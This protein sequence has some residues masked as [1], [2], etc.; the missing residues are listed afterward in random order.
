MKKPRS[1]QTA[2]P[3]AEAASDEEAL[4]ALRRELATHLPSA[5]REALAAYRRFSEGPAPANAK[6]FTAYQHACRAALAHVQVLVNLAAMATEA[7]IDQALGDD[8]E[9][10]TLIEAART[11]LGD[12]DGDDL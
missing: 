9:L 1:P 6:A 10:Q 11:A 4:A 12:D 5:L 8:A 2:G 3:P 7:S